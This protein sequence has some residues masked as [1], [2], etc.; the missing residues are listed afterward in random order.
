METLKSKVF[1]ATLALLTLYCV[2]TYSQVLIGPV[3]GPQISWTEFN[4]KDLRSTF[5]T[6]PVVRYHAGVSVSL[7]AYKRFFLTTSLLYSKKGKVIESN[8]DS[9]LENKV[10]YTHID[11]PIV[12]T[13]QFK[14]TLKGNKGFKYYIGG[15]PNISYWL[16]G[17]GTIASSDIAEGGKTN[18]PYKV[19]FRKSFDD[20]TENEMNIAD[21][22]RIQ[23]GIN[24]VAGIVLQPLGFNE[25]N[26]M[27]RYERGHSFL[28]D[29]NGIFPAATDYADVLASRNS[30]I[31]LSIAYMIDLK[32]DQR[33]KGKSTINKRKL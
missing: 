17:K 26:I 29:S 19:V 16:S 13:A 33:K 12:Y 6:S 2:T 15:G 21:P 4:D 30:G 5:S 31:R 8:V 18:I 14:G 22:N 25:V 27:L 32:T 10:V 11:M 28:G 3:A 23:I 1:T 24:V 7:R 20:I 9:K